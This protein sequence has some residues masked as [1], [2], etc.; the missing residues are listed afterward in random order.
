M[1]SDLVE[2]WKMGNEV[3]LFLIDRL[4]AAC[5]K[6]RYSPRTRTVAAQMAHIHNVRLRWIE[7]A[8]PELAGGA[9]RFPRGAEPTRAQLTRALRASSTAVER[10]LEA[11]EETGRVKQWKGSPATFLGYLVAHEA[12]HRGLAMVAMRL[13]GRK[14]PRELVYGLWD[15]GKKRSLR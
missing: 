10:F 5:L 6:D 14:L 3:N 7:H 12:H 15:W 8:A 4:D 11:S 9:K 1:A 13:S 2:A